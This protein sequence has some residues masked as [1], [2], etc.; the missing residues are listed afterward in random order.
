[1]ITVQK[2]SERTNDIVRVIF[3]MPAL[4]GCGD[5]YLVGWFD[6]WH[7]SVYRMQRADDGTW[8][9]ILELEPGCEYQYCFRTNDGTWLYD[10]DVPCTP[11]VYGSKNS[12][13]VSRN[14]VNC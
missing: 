5:L 1:M 10:P 4:D 13:V 14:G 7:E 6:E 2:I 12:F 8:N 3:T 11:Y 9:L